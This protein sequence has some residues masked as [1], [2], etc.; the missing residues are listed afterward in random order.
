MARYKALDAFRGLTIAL[1]ILV[2][3]P[4][5]WNHIYWPLGHA[6]WNGYTP[7]DL[8]FPFFLFI[9]GSAMFFSFKKSDFQFSGA[10]LQKV[11]KRGVMMFAIG[12]VLN[13]LNLFAGSGDFSELR[14]MGVLQRIAI[15]YVFAGAIVLL[16]GR[17]GVFV[18]SALLLLG[19][20][21]LLVLL[22]GDNPLG[23]QNNLVRQFD[24]VMLSGDHMWGGKGIPFDPEGLLSSIPA[25]VNVLLGFEATRY[26]TSIQNKSESVWRLAGLGVAAVLLAT[27]WDLLW[28]INKNLWSGSYV[29]V[30]TGWA[31]IV[32]AAFV[33][34]MD[35][36]GKPFE[37][38]LVY[39]MN[40]LF[41]YVVSWVWVVVY[42]LIP[43]GGG[44]LYDVVFGWILAGD[45]PNM[46]ASLLFAISHVYLFWLICLYLY[47]RNIVIKL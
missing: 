1:M 11:L 47:R 19:Y 39:G 10:A 33:W 23:L 5:S 6:E 44:N 2:N 25:I 8:V 26:L 35:V 14:I 9:I 4:G 22:G 20:W 15:A 21:A 32:L 30:T 24:L 38:L 45:S 37:P 31:L 18:V 13:A 41:I 40:P 12:L 27:I 17:I 36:K 3:T 16:V 42:Y 46:A 34:L 28:P 7:T 29:I 43:V